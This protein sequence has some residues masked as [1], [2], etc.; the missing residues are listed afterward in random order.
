MTLIGLIEDLEPNENENTVYQNL[1][2]TAKAVPKGRF[3]ALNA[4]S[5]K[6]NILKIRILSSHLRKLE[7][8]EQTKSKV[9]RRK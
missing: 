6:E 4:Y 7:R 3:I 2:D 9:R 5:K 1:W 8:E